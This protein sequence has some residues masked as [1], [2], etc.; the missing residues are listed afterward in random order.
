MLIEGRLDEPW[1]WYAQLTVPATSSELIRKAIERGTAP[2]ASAF[3]AADLTSEHLAAQLDLPVDA[4]E[5]LLGSPVA[6]PLVVVDGEDSVVTGAVARQRAIGATVQALASSRNQAVD[7]GTVSAAVAYRTAD[8]GSS[9]APLSDV[10]EI[11]RRLADAAAGRRLQAVVIP[12][13]E[14]PD[15][16]VVSERAIEAIE[17]DCGLALGSIRLL[18]LVETAGGFGRL[19]SIIDAAG[20]RLAGLIF[21][22]AD[23]AADLGLPS[24]DLR[25]PV[26]TLA[27]ARLIE[28]AALSG[29]PAVDGMTFAF[30]IINQELSP[31][32]RRRQVVEGMV[33][34]FRD[35]LGSLELGMAGKWLGHPAQLFALEL[36]VRRFY[37]SERIE[38]ALRHVRVLADASREGRGVAMDAGLMLDRATDRQARTFLA[39]AAAAGR[40]EL[41][42]IPLDSSIAEPA[43]ADHAEG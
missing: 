17:R 14:G 19:P 38:A 13:A 29:V 40:F 10:L 33:R 15:D 7:V 9:R 41:G 34:T 25:H 35:S 8:P 23:Y 4:V 1:H 22:V 12:K 24:T 28:A 36:A 42:R 32:D 26:A 39:R 18:L 5:S 37:S 16:V 43:S 3:A 20:P 2:V 11:S 30:P 27:R 6:A 21:G 31:E